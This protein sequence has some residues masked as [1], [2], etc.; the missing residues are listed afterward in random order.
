MG[1][2]SSDAAERIA[3]LREDR[4]VKVESEQPARRLAGARPAQASDFE[5]RIARHRH[6]IARYD[7]EPGGAAPTDPLKGEGKMPFMARRGRCDACRHSRGYR[8][9]G[10]TGR[11][12]HH[13]D[14]Q[15]LFSAGGATMLIGTSVA[16]RATHAALFSFVQ[17][18]T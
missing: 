7:D 10:R 6:K 14:D 15:R 1:M 9:L 12:R 17:S 13:V 16:P 3:E 11:A 5:K 4:S 18:L 8:S 2:D